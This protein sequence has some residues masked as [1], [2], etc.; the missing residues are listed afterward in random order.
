MLK[1]SKFMLYMEK[2]SYGMTFLILDLLFKN[3]DFLILFRFGLNNLKRTYVQNKLY[4][5]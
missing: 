3:Q 4:L 1:A 2:D 5:Y